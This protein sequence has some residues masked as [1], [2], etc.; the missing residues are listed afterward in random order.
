MLDP[1][2]IEFDLFIEDLFRIASKLKVR[3]DWTIR[4]GRTS[5]VPDR[6]ANQIERGPVLRTAPYSLSRS[7]MC[8]DIA[9]HDAEPETILVVGLGMVALSFIEKIK[10][11]D[12]NQVYEIKV[13]SE[14]PHGESSK[15][16]RGN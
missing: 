12:T 14:E 15:I 2:S 4:I 6:H 16:C 1:D 10:E 3:A 7:T 13:F 8:L 5:R 11:Y 9:T